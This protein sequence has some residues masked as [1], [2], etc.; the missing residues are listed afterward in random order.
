MNVMHMYVLMFICVCLNIH[1]R[2]IRMYVCSNS[3]HIFYRCTYVCTYGQTHVWMFNVC[4]YIRMYEYN[5]N[6]II[7]IRIHMYVFTCVHMY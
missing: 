2:Y 5:N 6:I 4:M 3:I 1:S 7:I